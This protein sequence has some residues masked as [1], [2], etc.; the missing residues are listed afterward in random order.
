[1]NAAIGLVQLDRLEAEFK[2]ARQRIAK[3][4]QKMLKPIK[5]I[6]LFEDDY[7]QTIPH[8]FP[9]RVLDGK[10]DL[11]REYLMDAGIECGIHY[12]PNHLLT[13]YGNLKGKLP[14]TEKIYNQLLS[15]PL[16]PGL[17]EEDQEYIIENIKRFFE[18][19]GGKK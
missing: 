15:I 1:I 8:I 7:E 18:T 14:A 5:G 9:I 19:T 4:Y 6:L 17:T 10:R 2:P 13:Y 11:L 16:H 12:Y 3:Y